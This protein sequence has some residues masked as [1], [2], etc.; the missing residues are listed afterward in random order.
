MTKY[1]IIHG[2]HTSEGDTSTPAR[3][4]PELIASGISEEDIITHDYGY[5][6]ALTSRW[7]NQAR[8]EKIALEI[9]HGDIIIA[10]SNGCDI[11]RRMLDRGILPDGVVLLQPALDVDTAF[12]L[13]DYWI[14][15]F[16]NAHDKA[17]FFAKCFLWFNHPYGAM[18]RYGY[19]G[20][21]TRIKNF[22]TL[23]MFGV[24]GHS[25]CYEI[26]RP[27]REKVVSAIEE[28]A[29]EVMNDIREDYTKIGNP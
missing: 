12:A 5:V 19:R 23:S 14:N 13:G 22:D 21:D 10:H 17:T 9:G 3:I 2:I 24:G 11:T 29:F 8:A 28:R 4:I 18:G 7:K 15:V 25:K 6:T 27:L 1:H 26:S 16:F 20:H